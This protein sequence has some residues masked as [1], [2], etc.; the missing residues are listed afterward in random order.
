MSNRSCAT[1][2]ARYRKYCVSWLL[3]FYLVM[4]ASN[5][6]STPIPLEDIAGLPS[7]K[8]LQISPN[9]R[10]ISSWGRVKSDGKE[11]F[12]L[13]VLDLNTMKSENLLVALDGNYRPLWYEWANNDKILIAGVYPWLFA[14][15]A[16]QK[17]EMEVLD[18]H[19][20][21]L[22]RIVPERLSKSNF[23]G[24]MPSRL[25]RVIDLLP[26]DEDHILMNIW[27]KTYKVSLGNPKVSRVHK[28]RNGAIGNWQVD[29]KSNVRIGYSFKG[30]MQT[31][32][33]SFP[34]S[35]EWEK[36]WVFDPLSPD[37]MWPIGF[38]SDP[39][40]L[41]VRA[42]HDDREA[43]FK[44]DLQKRPIEKVLVHA[45][46]NYDEGGRLFY[47]EKYQRVVGV[48]TPYNNSYIFWDKEY[49]SLYQAINKGL[50]GADNYL[51]DM[52]KDE[53]RYIV[54]SESDIDPGVYYFGD[55]DKKTLVPI[56][57]HY[58]NLQPQN[59]SK[60]HSFVYQARD[61]LDIEA[62]VTLP[63]NYKKGNPVPT[64]VLPH[65]G[66]AERD[67]TSFDYWT[68]FFASRG[69]MVLRINF[70][71]S[72]G[73]GY[74]FKRAGFGSWGLE[75]Q[76]DI[77]DGVRWAIE[78]GFAQKGKICIA[79]SGYGGYAA[80]MGTIRSPGLYECAISFGGVTDIP[81]LLQSY[82][83]TSSYKIETKR[84]SSSSKGNRNRS[85]LNHIQNIKTPVLL[86]HGKNDRE[87]EVSHGR[88]MYNALKEKKREV[89]YVELD[90]GSSHLHIRK[91]R[92]LAFKEMEAFLAEHL[93]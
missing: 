45:N 84:L 74:S 43:I 67:Y 13:N 36:L 78:K 24:Y 82:M 55:R 31:I 52:S 63:D 70:R 41:Y 5:V 93:Q 4:S 11:G 29:R 44:I 28:H 75:M 86:I 66:P 87:V 15:K 58:S 37:Y 34:G 83:R 51:I 25:D 7:V 35:K 90:K 60:T 49:D 1:T 8:W 19:S 79:G 89:R 81:R 21:A 65:D 85:P 64:V 14:G 68:Q 16:R 22:R 27:N 59:L 10:Y 9:G 6:L 53:R 77:E 30:K 3:A 92:I 56:A 61:G 54:F 91:N 38:D 20:K 39:N 26:D 33:H 46:E 72:S 76:D 48:T 69:Y 62:F 71:G 80:L 47:S 57:E 12:S 50:P 18:I 40:I 32:Y 23:G 42:L 88:R 17:T 73:Y 2:H